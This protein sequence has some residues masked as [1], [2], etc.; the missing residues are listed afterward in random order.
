MPLFGISWQKSFFVVITLQCVVVM[1]QLTLASRLKALGKGAWASVVES[2]L[3]F[4]LLIAVLIS[5]TEEDFVSGFV[6]LMFFNSLVMMYVLSKYVPL[7]KLQRWLRRSY[8]DCFRLGLKF[9][10]G[11]S[12]MGLFMAAPRIFLGLVSE[13]DVL[14]R[15]ALVFRWLSIAIVAHQFINTVYFKKIYAQKISEK[16]SYSL[17]LVVF[18]VGFCAFTIA[19]LLGSRAVHYLELPF[20]EDIDHVLVWTMALV[21][22]FWAASASLEGV[23]YR[24]EVA[25]LQALSVACGLGVLLSCFVAFYYFNFFGLLWVGGAWIL[26]FICILC[27]QF[28][29]AVKNGVVVM[30]V[31]SVCLLFSVAYLCSIFWLL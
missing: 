17:A 9:L 19:L 3:Y 5:S 14:G 26:G 2:S 23:L 28:G 13:P 22:V 18:G 6:F 10:V 4:L 15:F 24:A 7:P 30:P 21:M 25:N 11:A 12:L 20:P 16:Q 27:S 8:G 29:Y 1:L 31:V